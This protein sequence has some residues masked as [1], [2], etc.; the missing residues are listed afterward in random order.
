MRRKPTQPGQWDRR[1]VKVNGA[2]ETRAVEA[3]EWERL[4]ARLDEPGIDNAR[5]LL[6]DALECVGNSQDPAAARAFLRQARS[7]AI[8]IA[9]EIDA[10]L[11]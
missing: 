1:T 2:A 6:V 4:K 7:A 8:L 3:A 11:E 5:E 9:G 10:V